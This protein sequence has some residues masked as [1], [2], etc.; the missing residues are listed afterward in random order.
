MSAKKQEYEK[1]NRIFSS[2]SIMQADSEISLKD[3]WQ[4]K[5]QQERDIHITRLL[6]FYVSAY[7]RKTDFINTYRKKIV[8]V[9]L[10][11]LIAVVIIMIVTTGKTLSSP[12]ASLEQLVGLISAYISFS[13]LIIGL[14]KTITEYVFPKDDE[15]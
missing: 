11:V 6:S 3:R 5:Q 4:T 15:Q 8:E 2:I 14:I 13:A 12:I 10:A 7:D 9:L 1:L